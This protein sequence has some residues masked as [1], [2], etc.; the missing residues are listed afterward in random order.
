M[1]DRNS[2]YCEAIYVQV[3]VIDEN[4]I[5]TATVLDTYRTMEEE[6]PVT[7]QQSIRG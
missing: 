5:F 1:N 2:G 7:L 4:D 3:T 6:E